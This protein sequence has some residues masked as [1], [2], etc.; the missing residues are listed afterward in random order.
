MANEP[1]T[2]SSLQANREQLERRQARAYDERTR[3]CMADIESVANTIPT[4]M[5]TMYK[6]PTHL[7]GDPPGLLRERCISHVLEEVRKRGFF[8][9]RCKSEDLFISWDP[10]HTNRKEANGAKP[11]RRRLGKALHSSSED[12]DDEDNVITYRPNSQFG[13]LFLRTQLMAQNPK[14]ARHTGGRRR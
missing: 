4:Q 8:V 14:Y 9:R 13:N 2:A 12:D 3:R 1:L 7:D 11:K 5:Y 10:Q 6:V